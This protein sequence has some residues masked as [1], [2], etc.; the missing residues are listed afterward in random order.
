[1]RREKISF[2]TIKIF[3]LSI[4]FLLIFLSIQLVF[5]SECTATSCTDETSSIINIEGGIMC[6]NDGLNWIDYSTNPPAFT[7][8]MFPEGECYDEQGINSHVCCP[9]SA[10]CV[11][12][13]DEGDIYHICEYT[14]QD[15]CS[16]HVTESSC[17]EHYGNDDFVANLSVYVAN[18]FQ[19][20][21]CGDYNVATDTCVDYST[22]RCLWIS[23]ECRAYENRTKIC[24][25]DPGNKEETGWCSWKLISTDDQ[26]DSSG[27]MIFN[28]EANPSDP[29]LIPPA[30]CVN[31]QVSIP[32]EAIVKLDFFNWINFAV[33]VLFIICIYTVYTRKK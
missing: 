9:G 32:C 10:D 4:V 18:N 26:C 17:E 3:L 11:E 27:I 19:G 1:M 20:K 16:S 14:G 7:P 25:D 13:N 21:H 23:N 5:A 33:A 12:K 6:S 8:T 24:D 15:Y 22:C 28:F 29:P 31:K 30:D 2:C